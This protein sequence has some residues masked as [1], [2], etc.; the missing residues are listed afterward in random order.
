[1][2]QNPNKLCLEVHKVY[3][4]LLH[5]F[6]PLSLKLMIELMC[7]FKVPGPIVIMG[8][9]IVMF[10][11]QITDLFSFCPFYTKIQLRDIIQ[12]SL[13]SCASK[14]YAPLLGNRPRTFLPF[15]PPPPVPKKWSELFRRAAV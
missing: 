9:A 8:P 15:P 4:W 7:I 5:I 6:L 11:K 13:H 12:I 14:K 10:E 2:G 1:M 3:A